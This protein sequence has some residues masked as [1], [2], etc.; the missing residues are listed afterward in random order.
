MQLSSLK[1]SFLALAI[2]IFLIACTWAYTR[3]LSTR[4]DLVIRTHVINESREVRQNGELANENPPN[5]LAAESKNRTTLGSRSADIP[6]VTGNAVYLHGKAVISDVPSILGFSPS[7]NGERDGTDYVGSADTYRDIKMAQ[8]G[9]RFAL[10]YERRTRA[11]SNVVSFTVQAEVLAVFS[12]DGRLIQKF[13][14]DKQDI[15]DDPEHIF[16]HILYLDRQRIYISAVV[17]R[18]YYYAPREKPESISLN[19]V[20]VLGGGKMTRIAMNIMDGEL[21]TRSYSPDGRFMVYQPFLYDSKTKSTP[22]VE[23]CGAGSAETLSE[24]RILDFVHAKD[25]TVVRDVDK[26][27]IPAFWSATSS[28]LYILESHGRPIE[29]PTDHVCYADKD[30]GFMVYDLTTGLMHENTSADFVDTLRSLCADGQLIDISGDYTYCVART[31][32]Q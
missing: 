2:F 12:L 21:Q 29:H 24:V 30:D 3:Y 15:P 27:F 31:T 17:S 4:R 25:I 1:K 19:D 23:G 26:G 22:G 16:D 10:I 14:L 11:S 18:D 9:D 8:E 5:P 28:D 32:T 6:T 7:T 13:T 20:Y